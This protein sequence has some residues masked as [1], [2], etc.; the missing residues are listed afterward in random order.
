MKKNAFTFAETMIVTTIV[1]VL[2]AVSFQ[3]QKQQEEKV[4]P[5]LYS[6]AYKTLS[7]GCFNLIN[8]VENHN[9]KENLAAQENGKSQ[10]ADKDL[11]IFPNMPKNTKPTADV[12]CSNL[13]GVDG[14]MNVSQAGC[15]ITSA[16]ADSISS[17]FS[18]KNVDPSFITSDNMRYYITNLGS[19]NTTDPFFLVF[20]DLNGSRK[21]NTVIYDGKNKPDDCG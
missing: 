8:D 14:Y 20:I 17:S 5:R 13:A 10:A 6:K 2:V 9:L 4:L 7:T 11:K 3:I 21:P 18:L 12:L 16:P 1:G 15:N 19:G